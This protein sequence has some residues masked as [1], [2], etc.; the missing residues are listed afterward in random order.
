M[1]ASKPTLHAPLAIRPRL[2]LTPPS[3]LSAAA[4]QSA[5]LRTRS[6]ALRLTRTQ[7]N[8]EPASAAE[9]L[10]SAVAGRDPHDPKE[11]AAHAEAVIRAF[12]R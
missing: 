5:T 2:A 8:Q 7:T 1:A 12:L 4:L 6:Q 10:R 3:P 9:A 11:I